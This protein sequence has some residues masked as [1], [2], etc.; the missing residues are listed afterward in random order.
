MTERVYEYAVKE[1]SY[2][3]KT[4]Y[5]VNDKKLD[6]TVNSNN[7]YITYNSSIF[8]NNFNNSYNSEENLKMITDYLSKFE[9]DKC[10]NES[11]KN[12]SPFGGLGNIHKKL[13]KI[14]IFTHEPG[15]LKLNFV[16]PNNNHITNCFTI[17]LE[18]VNERNENIKLNKI[19]KRQR[20]IIDY[21]SEFPD[22]LD[23]LKKSKY[24]DLF[25]DK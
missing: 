16:K 6:I 1:I 13:E 14:I 23:I 2:T 12:S 3:I 4:L 22:T 7:S 19:I 15:H 21:L 5:N 11:T 17:Y 9:E 24:S 18:E 25:E 8:L 10:S 20:E